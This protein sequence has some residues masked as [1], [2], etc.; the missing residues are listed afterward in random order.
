MAVISVSWASSISPINLN[1]VTVSMPGSSTGETGLLATEPASLITG[2]A[3]SV[4]VPSSPGG[5]GILAT[6][7]SIRLAGNS[8]VSTGGDH[9]EAVQASGPFSS[10]T[11]DQTAIST[12]GD[13]SPGAGVDN[14]GSGQ[15]DRWFQRLDLR[16]IV[17]GPVSM[18][19]TAPRS[20]ETR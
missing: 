14:E 15:F 1:R 17:Y 20:A 6:G 9:A 18:A 13:R 4:S 16:H 8:T 5:H 12:T 2:S 7:G 3:V 19:V 10:I 11:L